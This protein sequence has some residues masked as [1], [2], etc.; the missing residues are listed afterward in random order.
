MNLKHATIFLYGL[1]T[2]F[3]SVNLIGQN[4]LSRQIQIPVIPQPNQVTLMNGSYSPEKNDR[5]VYEMSEDT[6]KQIMT[7]IAEE[8][9]NPRF[10]NVQ[11]HQYKLYDYL[12][13]AGK[14]KNG[15][16]NIRFVI[17]TNQNRTAEEYHLQI[18]E[19]N[20]YLEA[21]DVNGLVYGLQTM[22]QLASCTGHSLT[23]PVVEIHDRPRFSY[24]GVM[25]DISRHFFD[26]E[27][28]KKQIDVLAYY[29]INRLHLH[30]TDAAGW[31]IQ[32]DR[33]PRLTSRAAWRPEMK[34]K[35]WWNGKR[36]Y[37][38]ETTPGAYGGYLT[39]E[40][41]RE[42]VDYAQ[43]RAITIV[44]EIEMPSHSEE[45]LAVYPELSCSH[46]PYGPSD[47]CIGNEKTFRF[48]EQVLT[49]IMDLF[50]SEYIHIG[51]DEAPKTAWKTC[52]LCQRRIREENLDGVDGLQ[53]YLIHRIERFLNAHGRN[54]L[55][56]DEILD[57]GLAP[58]ATVMSWR[59][60]EGGL[61][62]VRSGHRAIMTPGAYCYLDSYQDAP[63]TQPEAIG[64]YLPLQKVYDYNPVPEGLDDSL[65]HL[66]YGVQANLWTEYI[67]TPEHAEYMLYPRVLAIAETG[68]TQ[69]ERKS[70]KDFHKQAL[71]A[72]DQMQK[73]GYHPFDLAKETGNRPE[74]NVICQHKAYNKPVLYNAPYWRTYPAAGEKALTDGRR[75]GWSYNDGNWQGF[76][77][78]RRLDVVIDLEKKDTI[79]TIE[80]DFMQ[81]CGPGVFL[82]EQIWIAT[83][84]DGQHFVPLISWINQVVKDDTLTIKRFTWTGMKTA[85]YIRYQAKASPEYGGVIFTDEIVI[86]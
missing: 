76:V 64:G 9:A 16:A 86:K 1:F 63:S 59:G 56:W 26:K 18:T 7:F 27:F 77:S 2:V 3:F 49:E 80:A 78:A 15:N 31:R 71:K 61:A 32:I 65:H 36:Y 42:L 55:G 19:N 84:E 10:T 47:F 45:V 85:R 21:G 23:L 48:L 50:P 81:I 22:A 51:G 67:P 82:P 34:W 52:L 25:I 24:R 44:P 66:I 20:I 35:D 28:L 73:S 54:L 74:A 40:D 75:G 58:N 29:K 38:R 17:S 83:S 72:V 57:G 60:T 14:R 4:D 68:W 30:L 62:T 8:K 13:K 43:K 12:L 37:T 53:S 41:V 39:K 5:V 6:R 33:Y 79:Q 11:A 46:Q 69:P 70:W